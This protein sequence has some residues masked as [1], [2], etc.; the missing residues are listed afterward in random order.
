MLTVF[1]TTYPL[2]SEYEYDRDT[3][4]ICKI[5]KDISIIRGYWTNQNLQKYVKLQILGTQVQNCT[6]EPK[7]N[8]PK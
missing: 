3:Q 7:C 1:L 8:F 5:Y 4:T 2:S 6:W